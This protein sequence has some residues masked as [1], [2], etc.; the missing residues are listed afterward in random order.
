MDKTSLQTQTNQKIA[1]LLHML[2]QELHSTDN[3]PQAE[4]WKYLS[5]LVMNHLNE[6]ISR[7]E[8]ELACN[9]SDM[10]MMFY[11]LVIAKLRETVEEKRSQSG[12]PHYGRGQLSIA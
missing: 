1:V 2:T 5:T 12:L 6:D 11:Q 7:F 3:M 9:Y 8:Q 10:R 4:G